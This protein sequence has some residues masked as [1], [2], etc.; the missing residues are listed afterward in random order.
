MGAVMSRLTL[1]DTTASGF[2]ALPAE[3]RNRIYSLAL[4]N[5]DPVRIPFSTY[6]RLDLEPGLLA[7]NKQIRAEAPKMFY[8][9]NT[10]VCSGDVRETLKFIHSL[11]PEKMDMLTELRVLDKPA[12]RYVLGYGDWSAE[13]VKSMWLRYLIEQVSLLLGCPVESGAL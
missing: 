2:L 12:P 5:P 6:K 13:D 3:I 9:E 11:G 4:V 7:T 1:D 8:A 10:F